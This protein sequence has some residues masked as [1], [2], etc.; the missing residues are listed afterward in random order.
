MSSVFKM[1]NLKIGLSND[2]T[3]DVNI[4]HRNPA[5]KILINGIEP[6]GGGSGGGPYNGPGD[7]RL[8]TGN[9]TAVGDGISNGKIEG[10]TI[11]SIDNIVISNGSL[12]VT[13]G[14]VDIKAN[15]NLTLEGNGNINQQGTGKIISGSNGIESKGEIKTNAA[16]DIHSGKDLVFDGQD[17]YKSYP[18]IVPAIPNKT[19]KEYK[20]LI[21]P[22]DNSIFTGTNIFRNNA[23][24]IQALNGAVPA[25]YEDKITLNTNGNIL[26]NDINANTLIKAN[27]VICENG[28][29]ESQ[30]VKAREFHF[31]PKSTETSGWKFSQKA[32][33]NPGIPEDNYLMLQNTQTTGSFNL[34]KSTFDPQNP[35]PFDIVLDPQNGQVKTTT[36]FDAPQ[37]NFRKNAVDNWSISQ[38]AS[39]G[40]DQNILKMSA[41]AVSS[42]I[43]IL[44]SDYSGANGPN[45][46][47]DPRTD[48]LGGL[49]AASAYELGQSTEAYK[50]EQPTTGTESNNL[51]IKAGVNEGQIK[52]QNN[53]GNID[54]AIIQKDSVTNQGRLYCP[55]IFFGT[56]G[57]H[58]SIVND[59]SGADSLVLKIKQATASSKVEFLD[60]TAASIMEVKKDEI[61][62]GP[63]IPILFGAY[64]FRPQQYYKDI[65]AFSF[66]HS[67][68]GATNLIFNTND[69][70]WINK[71]T[72]ATNQ[73]INMGLV[74]NRGAYKLTFAQTSG[75]SQNEINDFRFMSDIVLTQPNDNLPNVV[76]PSATVYSYQIYDGVAP[77]I[78]MKPGFLVYSVYAQFPQTSG[79]ETS[80]V[81][82]TLTQMPYFA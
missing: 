71:N 58:N 18:G 28:A 37:I 29:N 22:T 19:Y 10:Q 23:V 47:L 81:R 38:P 43:H 50:L 31:R 9:L 45:I 51:L 57:I 34:V 3:N 27:S 32:P 56:T 20:N 74:A 41:P 72:E 65:S 1:S 63:S 15:G 14:G 40:A 17:I 78:T 21:A 35:T 55:A 76:L 30:L 54:L 48:A 7:I 4:E 16:N 52:F 73:T 69:T 62:L 77:I 36:S 33:D 61:E 75:G 70:D 49:I 8:N 80:N 44:S 68:L 26:C 82:I 12:E 2:D 25:V 39:G 6:G 24:S 60:N 5:H 46:K 79:N 67:S 59:T 11:K 42:E 13:T 66:N 53:S 64:S